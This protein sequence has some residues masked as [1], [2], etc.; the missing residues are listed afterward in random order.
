VKIQVEKFILPPEQMIQYYTQGCKNLHV[1]CINSRNLYLDPQKSLYPPHKNCILEFFSKHD[2]LMPLYV[3]KWQVHNW[4]VHYTGL[5]EPSWIIGVSRNPEKI[6]AYAL[7]GVSKSQIAPK[8]RFK[9]WMIL[10]WDHFLKIP[11]DLFQ[12]L[13]KNRVKKWSRRTTQKSSG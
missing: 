13:H 2:W 6:P 10:N 9:K 12:K 3:H 5:Q 1:L 11:V 4:Q 8:S 7:K